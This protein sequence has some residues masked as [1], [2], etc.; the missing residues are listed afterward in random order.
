M[1]EWL[2]SLRQLYNFAL[3]ERRDTYKVQ[4]RSVSVYEQ[5]RALPKLKKR[6]KRYASIHSQVLQDVLFRLDK[7]FGRFF[8]GGG[9]PR[10]KAC[11]RYRSFTYTQAPITPKVRCSAFLG[12]GRSLPSA[13]R[14]PR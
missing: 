5:K 8:A 10:F 14:N 3:T 1:E 11:D 4:G 13:A 9:Y 12:C 2:A 7:A 6:S